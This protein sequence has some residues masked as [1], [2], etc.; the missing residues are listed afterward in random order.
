MKKFLLTVFCLL[1]FPLFALAHA[2]PISYE[3]DASALLGTPASRV[4]ITFSEHVEPSASSIL[5]FAP[6][7]KKQMGGSMVEAKDAHV[8]TVPVTP[9]GDGAYTVSWQVVSADDGHFTKGAYSFF[10][11][12]SSVPTLGM[13]TLPSFSISH[14][15]SIPEALSIWLK[16][17]G[18]SMLLG[19]FALLFLF[20][21]ISGI[22]MAMREMLLRFARKFTWCAVFILVI[23]TIAY[24][25]LKTTALMDAQGIATLQ[26]LWGYSQT[27]AGMLSWSLFVLTLF[28]LPLGL[29]L[30]RSFAFGERLTM[31]TLLLAIIFL[32][33]SYTQAR[34]SH[35]AA[36]EFLPQFSVFVNLFHLFGKGL[37]VGS[38][39][40]LLCVFLPA[41]DE[42]EAGALVR[43]KLFACLGKLTALAMI[44]GGV[45][46]VWI[47]WL[48]L[49]D[50]TNI[51]TSDWGYVFLMLCFFAAFLF[52][53]RMV[54]FFFF[55]ERQS[56]RCRACVHSFVFL[57]VLVAVSVSFFSAL[58]I[59]T[60]PPLLHGGSWS[61]TVSARG[62]TMELRDDLSR[63]NTLLLIVTN[64][65]GNGV[66]GNPVITLSNSEASIGPI[67]VPVEKRFPGGFGIDG[68]NFA[69]Q[70][71]WKMDI[72][73]QRAG[74]YDAVGSFTIDYPN[75]IVSYRA[76]AAGRH[77]GLF[78]RALVLLVLL[79]IIFA[80][81]LYIL[82]R[83]RMNVLLLV[84]EDKAL[85]RGNF[86]SAFFLT[87]V[88]Y[89][90]IVLTGFVASKNFFTS[91]FQK[92]CEANEGFWNQT[93]PMHDG[94]ALSSLARNGCSMGMGAGMSHY[95]DLRELLYT[96]R[97]SAPKTTLIM[98][99]QF[100]IAGVP[101]ILNFHMEES[102]AP[103]KDMTIEHDRLL[104][105]III[106]EDFAH[107]AHIHVE[108]NTPISKSME[109]SGVYP[110]TYTFPVAGRYLIALDYSVRTVHKHEQ[111]VVDVLGGPSPVHPASDFTTK[112]TFDGYV[113]TLDTKATKETAN[114]MQGMA[115]M[116]MHTHTHGGSTLTLNYHIEKDGVPVTDMKPYLAAPMHVAV[117]KD[118]LTQF[119]HEH[120][121]LP[122][123]GIT[124]LLTTT[125]TALGLVSPHD[126]MSMGGHMMHMI[127]PDAFGP[128]LEASIDVPSSGT[129]HI[130]GEF[131]RGSDHIV[132]HFI[133]KVP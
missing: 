107:F 38:L 19:V 6:D 21:R 68:K 34:L 96:L 45:S 2:T 47:V 5:I 82:A 90:V 30:L 69:P 43:Q 102:G 119:V 72:A 109:E 17:L 12:T 20:G 58:I 52:L 54:S 88:T 16:L 70:G 118:D 14:S 77:F 108:D 79:I 101:V 8:L 89:A 50:P 78:E 97:P 100:P 60:T 13:S 103:L 28:F 56:A 121:M 40:A 85:P 67:L 71:I 57:E 123:T 117:V 105:T 84:S 55:E 80:M 51:M 131:L 44:I 3:P 18:E 75:S 106:S 65:S 92:Q 74:A 126:H 124:A 73:L 29:S 125:K 127:V 11:G 48:H 93:V 31:K 83:R 76:V 66:D 22:D 112:K 111:F 27:T 49:K 1:S 104:H 91:D 94:V 33:A 42:G 23:G 128:D 9:A 7:G 95:V 132:T 133:V 41:L 113:V 35:A 122:E 116:D 61:Q 130:F 25:T 114:D 4:T 129:Y 62:V 39:I 120:A 36:S 24:I 59:I 63:T 32:L 53:F 15:S 81:L 37:W 110:L 99:P 26:A 87:L 98:S 46:G 10:V 64:S 115:G 86:S